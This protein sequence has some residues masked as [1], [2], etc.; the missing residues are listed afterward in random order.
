MPSR[1]L[2][3]SSSSDSGSSMST[4]VPAKYASYAARSKLPWPQRL[5]R[6]VFE[7]PSSFARSTSATTARSACVGSGAGMMPSVRAKRTASAKHSR[8]G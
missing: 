8:C 5:N 4:I 7:T 1:A 3:A 6:I 2:A